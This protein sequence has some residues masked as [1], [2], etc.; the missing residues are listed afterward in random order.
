MA[1]LPAYMIL[2]VAFRFIFFCAVSASLL[3]DLSM[4]PGRRKGVIKKE[5]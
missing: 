5:N 3:I 4:T 2:K 1:R